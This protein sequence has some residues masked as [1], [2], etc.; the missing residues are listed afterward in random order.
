MFRPTSRRIVDT[1]NR[2]T[3][4]TVRP[5][6]PAEGPKLAGGLAR[7]F[8]DD[9]LFA[10]LI[11]DDAR[12]AKK[13][14]AWFELMLTKLWPKPGEGEVFTTTALA[15]TAIWKSPGHWK[16][17]TSDVLKMLPKTV[18]IF[19]P[20]TFLRLMKALNALEKVHPTDEHWYLEGLGTDPIHQR[21]G[22]GGAVMGAILDRCDAEG[23]P[24]YLET[25]K[26]PNVAY[27]RHH[28]FEVRDELVDWGG[29]KMWTMWREPR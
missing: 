13:L 7:A 12:R 21:K 15:G 23:I 8:Q 22:V 6:T 18:K 24:A 19:G 5:A 16:V 14:D 27:Y 29:P 1:M 17:P 4:F 28:G 26:L 3:T 11:P 20:G 9:P 2:E 10:W 25:Q